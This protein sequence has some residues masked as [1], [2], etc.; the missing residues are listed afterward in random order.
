MSAIGGRAIE[1]D[2]GKMGRARIDGIHHIK[3]MLCAHA[4]KQLEPRPILPTKMREGEL[5]H[6]PARLNACHVELVASTR[7]ITPRKVQRQGATADA[8][9]EQGSFKV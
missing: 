5:V 8:E 4:A 1:E 7:W 6:E 9:E 2:R 3:T